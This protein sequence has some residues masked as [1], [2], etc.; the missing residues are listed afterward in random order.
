MKQG[1]FFAAGKAAELPYAACTDEY[2][3]WERRADL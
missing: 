1:Q 2:R 3:W